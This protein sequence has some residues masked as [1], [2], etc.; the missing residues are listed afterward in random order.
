MYGVKQPQGDQP[1]DEHGMQAGGSGEAVQVELVGG[2]QGEGHLSPPRVEGRDGG[3]LLEEPAFFFG[4]R[5]GDHDPDLGKKV[6]PASTRVGQAPASKA[7][8]VATRCSCF[9]SYFGLTPRGVDSD[10]D[11]QGRLPRR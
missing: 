7:E 8:A 4:E 6:A 11:A 2:D 9:D 1:A 10:R 5:G 3:Q